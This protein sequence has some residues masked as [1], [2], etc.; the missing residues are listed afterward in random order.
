MDREADADLDHDQASDGQ[1]D[2]TMCDNDIKQPWV[3]PREYE[4]G[5]TRWLGDAVREMQIALHPLLEGIPRVD[6]E[7][8]PDLPRAGDPLPVEASSLYRAASTSHQWTI[9]IEDV[10]DF[11]VDQFLV[12]LVGIAQD[13]GGQVVQTFLEHVST[14][15]EAA[16]NVV[17]AEGRSIHDAFADALE[18]MDVDFDEDGNHNL[19]VVVSPE[20]AK[21]MDETPPTPEQQERIHGILL[22]KR[23]EWH[24]ARR[25]RDLP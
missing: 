14:V 1:H 3:I 8:M 21:A 13:V 7:D 16:G 17:N 22:K 23:E 24:A 11:N 6:V 4:I 15:S 10:V 12:D 25:S 2:R 9:N 19:S 18:M 20:T 5:G